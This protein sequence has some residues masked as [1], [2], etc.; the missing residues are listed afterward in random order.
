MTLLSGLTYLSAV[1]FVTYG[2]VCLLTNHMKA[3]FERYGLSRYRRLVGVLELVGGLGLI[4]GSVLPL[5]HFAS[6]GGLSLL[7][8]LGLHARWRVGDAPVLLLPA[9]LLLA[10]NAWIFYARL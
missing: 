1:A 10:A 3:E 8:L 7:M 5:L 6:A 9:T 2:A 4:V